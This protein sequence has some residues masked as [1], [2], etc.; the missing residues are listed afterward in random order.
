METKKKTVKF[1]AHS[2]SWKSKKI[3]LIPDQN[4]YNENIKTLLFH[5][6]CLCRDSVLIYVLWMSWYE[7]LVMHNTAFKMKKRLVSEPTGVGFKFLVYRFILF[8]QRQAASLHLF[9]TSQHLLVTMMLLTNSSNNS[10]RQSTPED[11]DRFK[12]KP[13]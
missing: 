10:W 4:F 3:F 9:V 6:M 7:V 2:F 11:R 12:E 1:K 8:V 5:F 13:F